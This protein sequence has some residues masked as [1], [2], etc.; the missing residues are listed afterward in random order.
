M[1]T[2]VTWR[3]LCAGTRTSMRKWNRSCRLAST[4]TTTS[5]SPSTTSVA[6]RRSWLRQRRPSDTRGSPCWEMDASLLATSTCPC[7]SSHCPVTTLCSTRTSSP[8]GW[9]G[10]TTIRACS[11]SL[12]RQ[13]RQSIHWSVE[14]SSQCYKSCRILRWCHR[15]PIWSV[16][17]QVSIISLVVLLTMCHWSGQSNVTSVLLMCVNSY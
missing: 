14:W 3:V 12:S 6:R 16:H 4:T 13:C 5:S 15:L 9:S 7:H 10:W 17:G 11:A 2:D 1:S 8:R